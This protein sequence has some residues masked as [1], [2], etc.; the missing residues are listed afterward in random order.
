MTPLTFNSYHDE[1]RGIDRGRKLRREGSNERNDRRYYSTGGRLTRWIVWA[2]WRWRRWHVR[3][4]TRSMINGRQP[5]DNG[6]DSWWP[7]RR[8]LKERWAKREV[9]HT[10][11]R[12]KEKRRDVRLSVDFRG[13]QAGFERGLVRQRKWVI[14]SRNLLPSRHKLTCK[15]LTSPMTNQREAAPRTTKERRIIVRYE[16]C[17]SLAGLVIDK[18]HHYKQQRYYLNTWFRVSSKTVRRWMGVWAVLD[19]CWGWAPEAR[20]ES[21][22]LSIA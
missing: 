7:P 21:F 2:S 3:S 17:E 13:R 6:R 1:N 20:R 19:V 11:Y 16:H 22:Y 8:I 15:S 5:R 12:M 4:V 18:N 9:Y 10:P 14:I